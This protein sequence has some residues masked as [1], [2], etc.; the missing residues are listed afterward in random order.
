VS[1]RRKEIYSDARI[2]LYEYR[3]FTQIYLYNSDLFIDERGSADELTAYNKNAYI[4][5][6]G[7]ATEKPFSVL[8]TRGLVDLNFLS[9]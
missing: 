3:P 8:A 5:F 4:C 6:I 2:V 9:A 7:D 1:V